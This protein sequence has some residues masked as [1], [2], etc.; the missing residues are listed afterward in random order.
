MWPDGM[1]LCMITVTVTVGRIAHTRRL[2]LS[3]RPSNCTRESAA[4]CGPWCEH[5]IPDFGDA[6]TEDHAVRRLGCHYRS[7]FMMF[8]ERQFIEF[9]GGGPKGGHSFTRAVAPCHGNSVMR[10]GGSWHGTV[11]SVITVI[12]HTTVTKKEPGVRDIVLLQFIIW[13]RGGEWGSMGTAPREVPSQ[14]APRG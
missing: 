1:T 10:K 9:L 3:E 7:C 11:S 8:D 13:A 5:H 2:L 6:A 12:S 4:G 14:A